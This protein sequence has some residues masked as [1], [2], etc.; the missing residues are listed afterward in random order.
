MTTWEKSYYTDDLVSFLALNADKSPETAQFLIDNFFCRYGHFEQLNIRE[1]I[2]NEPDRLL[3]TLFPLYATSKDKNFM[4][5]FIEVTKPKKH[6]HYG[7]SATYLLMSAVYSGKFILDTVEFERWKHDTAEQCVRMSHL[8]SM[9]SPNQLKNI[10]ESLRVPSNAAQIILSLEMSAQ[11]CTHVAFAWKEADYREDVYK[12]QKRDEP[13]PPLPSDFLESSGRW[14]VYAFRPLVVF[15]PEASSESACFILLRK[16][17]LRLEMLIRSVIRALRYYLTLPVDKIT[18]TDKILAFIQ[19]FIDTLTRTKR[20]N[21]V[22]RAWDVVFHIFVAKQCCD[23][24][25]RSYDEQIKKF[26]DNKYG[27]IVSYNTVLHLLDGIPIHTCFDLLKI[28]KVLPPPDFD[29]VAGF[30]DNKVHHDNPWTYGN[31]H[32]DHRSNAPDLVVSDDEFFAFQRLQL[33][34]RVY[35]MLGYCPGKLTLSGI[36]HVLK[37]PTSSLAKFPNVR[38]N[39]ILLTEIQYIDFTDAG[40]WEFKNVASPDLYTDK[41]SPPNDRDLKGILDGTA[42]YQM[43]IFE[44]NYLM[45]YLT[46]NDHAPTS[47]TGMSIPSNPMF[48]QVTA[49][50]KPESKKPQPRNFYSAKPQARILMTE[51]ESNVEHYLERDI[52]SFIS[53]DPQERAQA[54]HSLLGLDYDADL[55]RVVYVSFDLDKWSPRFSHLGKDASTRVWRNFFGAETAKLIPELSKDIDIHHYHHGIHLNYM[56]KTLDPE[57]MWGKTN[58]AYHE[59]VMAYTVR[60]LITGK[61]LRYPAKLAVFI[62][63]GLLTLK[64]DKDTTNEHIIKVLQQI[65]YTYHYF[66]FHISW[67]KTF[68]SENYATFLSEYYYRRSHIDMPFRAFLKMQR[69]KVIDEISPLGQIKSLISMGRASAQLGVSPPLVTY[70]LIHEILAVFSQQIR[71][72]RQT[73]HLAPLEMALFLYTPNALGGAGLQTEIEM[74]QNPTGDSLEN[75]YGFATYLSTI[76]SNMRKY[77]QIILEQSTKARTNL[78]ILR[79]PTAVSTHGPHLSDMR[80]YRFCAPK[81]MQRCANTILKW[82]FSQDLFLLADEII[83]TL[84]NTLSYI[85]VSL[86]YDASP[87]S[88]YDKFLS[89]IKRGGTVLGL[90]NWR[91]R[92]RVQMV[93]KNEA[94]RVIEY[95]VTLVRKAT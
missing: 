69:T 42:F 92:Q 86:A 20:Y 44:R 55:Y 71:Q 78:S 94:T 23:I 35:R 80:H 81:L 76:T 11:A 18:S 21:E 90:L 89:R 29:P 61:M 95:F 68:V 56:A 83:K 7:L 84:P 53:K 46:A 41:S 63:D 27:E 82:I 24:W 85:D 72:L 67:D 8:N 13:Y 45:Y 43:P 26:D 77:F 15:E 74:L 49:H 47:E 17:I 79:A 88:L 48:H 59:D 64:F 70:T 19:Y 3:K 87:I 5:S 32:P 33:L 34:R 10:I 52:A 37:H 6:K 75:F 30:L 12:A 9:G 2:E 4:K 91:G 93:Y 51:W 66:G 40:R 57:G 65:E 54:L 31:E 14:K 39:K 62:D 38:P 22:C 28:Y 1:Y 73:I 58:T 50:F 60:K 25:S 36:D 16:D